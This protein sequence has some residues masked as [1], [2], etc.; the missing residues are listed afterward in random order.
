MPPL[1]SGPVQLSDLARMRGDRR[2]ADAARS[3]EEI[4][5]VQALLR[6]RVGERLDDVRLAHQ[7]LEIARPVLAREH[8]GRHPIDSTGRPCRHSALRDNAGHRGHLASALRLRPRLRSATAARASTTGA[9]IRSRS[10]P[11]APPP[12]P[13]RTS[14][15]TASAKSSRRAANRRTSS[16]SARSISRASSSAWA[17]RR[18]S[19]TRWPR[20]PARSPTRASPRTRS[21]WRSTT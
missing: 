14:T 15:R 7:R 8:G 11:S 21:R 18:S 10:P 3:G 2:L 12:R 5:V 20:S 19:P 1:P 9:S 6:E 4:G 17:R 13:P 16:T